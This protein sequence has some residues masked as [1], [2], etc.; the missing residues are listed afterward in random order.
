LLQRPAGGDALFGGLCWQRATVRSVTWAE[1]GRAMQAGQ[2]IRKSRACRSAPTKPR[3]RSP[4]RLAI[5]R[6][7]LDHN[8][9]LSGGRIAR[10]R[11]GAV[12]TQARR[13]RSVLGQRPDRAAPWRSPMSHDASAPPAPAFRPPCRSAQRNGGYVD[14]AG[15]LALQGLFTAHVTGNF[16]TLGASLVLE[17]GG[18]VAKLISAAGVLRRSRRSRLA[19]RP[20]GPGAERPCPCCWSPSWRCWFW[21]ASWR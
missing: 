17:P 13:Y 8:A 20:C 1:C 18:A 2:P 7:Q 6:L 19:A 21:P 3:A 11:A 9:T 16:V 14:A 4:D 5:A 15:F 12:W 10:P